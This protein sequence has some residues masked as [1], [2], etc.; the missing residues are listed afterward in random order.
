MAARNRWKQPL[1]LMYGTV[2]RSGPPAVKS[3]GKHAQELEDG[4]SELWGG[5]MVSASCMHIT[6]AGLCEA[7]SST[8]QLPVTVLPS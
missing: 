3:S 1:H 5:M 2:C 7:E 8:V 6:A 4:P